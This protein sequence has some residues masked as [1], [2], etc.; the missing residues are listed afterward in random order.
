VA[1]P[2][3]AKTVHRLGARDVVIER[4]GIEDAERILRLQTIAYRSEAELYHNP[5]IP[6]MIQT[7]PDLQAQFEDHL[8]LKA[9]IGGGRI[10]GSVRAR[11]AQGTCFVGRLVVHPEFQRQGLGSALMGDIE[12][13]FPQATRFEL[14]TGHRSGGNLALYRKLGYRELRR[15]RV[16][17]T[18]ELVYLEK[19]NR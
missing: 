18:L 6:P 14:F 10:V 2:V 15:E 17:A 3:E 7:L 16:D 12:K 11:V 9:A 8:I 5:R 1:E 4:A 19:L 13:R